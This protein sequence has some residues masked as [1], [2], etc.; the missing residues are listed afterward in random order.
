MSLEGYLSSRYPDIATQLLDM[1]LYIQQSAVL[2]NQACPLPRS[3]KVSWP[4]S[5]PS[6]GAIDR[7][8]VSTQAMCA[9]AVDRLLA[10]DMATLPSIAGLDK[11]C[12]A[13]LASTFAQIRDDLADKKRSYAWRSGTFGTEDI[14]KTLRSL[15]GFTLLPPSEVSTSLD[16][17]D[18]NHIV[19]F[20][21]GAS[22]TLLDRIKEAVPKKKSFSV[23][24]YGP[25]GVSKTTLAKAIAKHTEWDL[26]LITPSDFISGGESA[27]EQR[28]KL[29]FDT[30]SK[31]SGVVIFFDEID[32]LLLD[33]DSTSYGKQHDI[34]QFMT[35]SMLSKLAEL[36]KIKNI[37][38]I[39]ATNYAE[40]IDR[41]IKRKGRI[42]KTLL[43]VPFNHSAR[44]EQLRLLIDKETHDKSIWAREDQRKLAAVAKRIPCCV[45]EELK[46]MVDK[47]AAE[48]G[49][50]TRIK[51]LKN[52]ASS[53]PENPA[54]TEE[55]LLVRLRE[56][57]P[58]KPVDEYLAVLI[59]Q[60]EAG[61]LTKK[62]V[63]S[64]LKP[65]RSHLT[66]IGE[67]LKRLAESCNLG[68]ILDEV[69]VK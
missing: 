48:K 30:L 53:S 55:S 19:P 2:L 61:K 34:F 41:A 57:Y 56:D 63:L 18:E 4:Y 62:K 64:K 58:Q 54:V 46:L 3:G 51:L 31:M 10:S 26:V 35:P 17:G 25:P 27:I 68:A 11:V 39:I 8:S 45:W 20:D 52:L 14:Q 28:A 32:R 69:R 42:D 49:K 22:K 15:S 16:Q 21:L 40:R 12:E 9:V 60:A 24:L 29:I 38:F 7:I 33:R 44:N 36:R 23:L 67:D 1:E 65:Y 43:C 47:A 13:V 37:G 66:E 6:S 50:K 5:Y 59:L